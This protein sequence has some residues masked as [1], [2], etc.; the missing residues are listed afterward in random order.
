MTK[1][2]RNPQH[3]YHD[4]LGRRVPESTE[5]DVSFRNLFHLDN[6]PWMR[7]HK[8]AGDIVFPFAGYAEMIGES[9]LMKLT[10]EA[11]IVSGAI[12][13]KWLLFMIGTYWC[14]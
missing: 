6:A 14:D 10:I 2:W 13:C 3:K 5:Y 7:D 4:L 9:I 11:T 1:E 12:L 8:I